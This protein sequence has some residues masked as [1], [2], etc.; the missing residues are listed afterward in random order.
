MLK[1]VKGFKNVIT[2]VGFDLYLYR[3]TVSIYQTKNTKTHAALQ[4]CDPCAAWEVACGASHTI[5]ATDAGDM[6]V[7][8]KL[9][10]HFVVGT[11][12]GA[13][14]LCM[15]RSRPVWRTGRWYHEWLRLAKGPSLLEHCHALVSVDK[16]PRQVLQV[17]SFTQDSTLTS[18]SAG[19]TE[20][21]QTP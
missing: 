6:R 2:Q 21:C 4:M 14:C 9:P 16:A 15:Y 1:P 17:L 19:G 20:E 11:L 18:R 8:G 13:A 12:I 5:I 7:W 3:C 10:P